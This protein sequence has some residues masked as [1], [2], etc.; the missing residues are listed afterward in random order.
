MGEQDAAY[1]DDGMSLSQKKGLLSFETTRVGLE[2]IMLSEI[3]KRKTNTLIS[4]TENL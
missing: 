1:T 4:L 2:G 3:S